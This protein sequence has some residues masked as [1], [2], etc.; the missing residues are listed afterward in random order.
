MAG[1]ILATVDGKVRSPVPRP[2]ILSS[3]KTAWEGFA[4]EQHHTPPF[5]EYPRNIKFPGHLITL[6]LS[7]EPP[8]LVYRALGGKKRKERLA[9]GALS[10]F[11]AQSE[12][13]ESEQYGASMALPLLIHH[14]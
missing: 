5:A 9:N 1:R 6:N 2:P 12:L 8:L 10:L 3:A 11:P 13:V 4:L 7:E 14:L